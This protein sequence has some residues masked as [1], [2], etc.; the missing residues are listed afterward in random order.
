MFAAQGILKVMRIDSL[1][2]PLTCLMLCVSASA[3]DW[4]MYLKDLT[5][6]S[7]NNAEKQ[8]NIKTIATLQPAWTTSLGGF[9]SAGVTL[10]NGVLYIGNWSGNFFAVD[11]QTGKVIWTVFVGKAPDPADPG[12]MQGIGVAGQ[13]TVLGNTVYVGGG[14]SAVYALD[15]SN[16]NQLWRVPLADPNTGSYLWASMVPYNNVLFVGVASLSDCPIVRGALAR[17]DLANPQQPLLR[18][19]SSEDRLGAG[20]WSTPAIDAATNTVFAAVGNGDVQDVSTGNYSEAM[21]RFDA[22]TLAV[23]STFLLPQDEAAGDL[24]WGSSPTLFNIPGGGGSL[25]AATGKDGF[26]YAANQS[27]LSLVWKTQLAVGC[28]APDQ[29]CGS[30]S[31]PAFDGTT[32]FVG[33]GVR[34]PTLSFNGSVYA[35]NPANGLVLWEHDLDGIVI[36]PVTVANGLVFAGTTTGLRIFD[37]LTGQTV[38]SD[39]QR[40]LLYSQPVVMNGTIYTTYLKGDLVAWNLPAVGPTT[41]FNFSAASIIPAFAPNTI[42]SLFGTNLSGASVNVSDSSGTQRAAEIFYSS[43][44]QINYLIPDGTALGR[45]T[46]NVS[47]VGTKL[48]GVIEISNVAPGIFSANSD[49]KG[50]A[51]AQALRVKADGTRTSVAVVQCGTSTGSC[52]ALPI[53]L[54][55]SGDQVF[56]SLYGTGLRNRTALGNVGCTIGGV[57]VPVLYA[58]AQMSFDGLDQVDVQIPASLRGRGEVDVVLSVDGQRANTVRVSIQ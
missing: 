47:A 7:F 20:I 30:L 16:G 48:S 29:G 27:D 11:A 21:L 49:G 31:T 17:I 44:N 38:W 26:L 40:G 53:D 25:V 13:P 12:C 34:D 58:G 4:P 22:D 50:V 57:S 8:L 28:V 37:S 42:A 46:V 55:S 52:V 24:D 41:V 32:L 5:H 35:I 45:A 33:A 10:S 14:D 15:K 43:A 6:S 51:A 39:N 3:Q 2:V 9:L 54:G 18:Y 1:H 56:L 19:M 23:K 36:A